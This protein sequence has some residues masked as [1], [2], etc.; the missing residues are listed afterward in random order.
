MNEYLKFPDSPGFW[1][2]NDK[3]AYGWEVVRVEKNVPH[4]E[5][6]IYRT[7]TYY[8]EEIQIYCNE[9][10]KIDKPDHQVSLSH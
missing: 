3:H 2:M 7:G 1:W 6:V 8:A 9:W 10:V 4:C 5:Y